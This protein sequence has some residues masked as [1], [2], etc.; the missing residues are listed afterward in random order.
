MEVQARKLG[1]TKPF[2]ILGAALVLSLIAVF[3]AVGINDGGYRTVVQWPNGKMFV[4]F[5]EGM[6]LRAFGTTTEY[7]NIITFDFDKNENPE[8][9]TIDQ[10]GIAVRYQDGGTGTVYGLARF[11][12]PD[13]EASMLELHR[14]FRSAAGVGHKLIKSVSEE[15]MN[16]TAGLMTSEEAYAE[17]RGTFTSWAQ[18]QIAAG[19]FITKLETTTVEDAVTGKRVSKQ[20]PVIDYGDDGLPKQQP[21]AFT[22]YAMAM[23]SLQITDWDFEP[24]TLEQI[25]AKREANMA[26]I[27]SKANAE[28]AKQEAEEAVAQGEKDVTVAKYEKEV[29]KT[30][31]I[32]EA[33][34]AKAVAEIAAA[35]RVAV[36]EQAKLEAEQMRLAA[37]EYKGEQILRGEGDAAYKKLV[38]EADGAL[39]QKL[40]AMVQMNEDA[41]AAIAEQ[42]WVPEISLG[43]AG[44]GMG[45]GNAA[46]AL[47]QMMMVNYAKQLDVDMT[48]P[49]GQSIQ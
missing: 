17:Q 5:S 32:V 19:K 4:K 38:L 29:E 35:Q 7:P 43:E 2:I 26:I 24:K 25:D 8:G 9:T 31:A 42:R 47:L 6:Y 41:W 3:G 1:R 33:E 44:T 13:D 37:A 22:P 49:R 48:V 23:T 39:A 18:Q 15:S 16:L 30:R 36:A 34:Q 45:E 40:E 14:D 21:S 12:L 10:L 27:T 46:T 11:S 28:R 20:V